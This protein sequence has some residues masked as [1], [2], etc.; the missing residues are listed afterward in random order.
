MLSPIGDCLETS[1]YA[2]AFKRP[3]V[4]LSKVYVKILMLSLQ[5]TKLLVCLMCLGY[6]IKKNCKIQTN[7]TSPHFK[8]C[9]I[10]KKDKRAT[11][12]METNT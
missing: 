3:M 11:P 4:R 1:M 8:I 6:Y 5:T 12:T 10:A 2:S 7:V 9:E